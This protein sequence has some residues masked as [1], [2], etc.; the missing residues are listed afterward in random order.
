MLGVG[1]PIVVLRRLEFGSRMEDVCSLERDRWT[2]GGAGVIFSE[3][4]VATV[5]SL[6]I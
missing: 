2:I 5:E 1:K 3:L 6:S 4:I